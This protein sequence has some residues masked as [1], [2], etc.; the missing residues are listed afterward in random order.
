MVKLLLCLCVSVSALQLLSS[1]YSALFNSSASP[2]TLQS[3]SDSLYSLETTSVYSLLGWVKFDVFPSES[4]D[5]WRLYSPKQAKLTLKRAV[6]GSFSL[7]IENEC[8]EVDIVSMDSELVRY[9]WIYLALSVNIG[10]NTHFCL[11]MAYWGSLNFIEKCSNSLFSPIYDQK[12]SILT[13]GGTPEL[14][15]QVF[16]T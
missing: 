14:Y 10:Q 16:P 1:S 13:L 4:V 7:N 12:A 8:G 11:L 6:D 9:Q 3:Y 5:L 2:L 15:F